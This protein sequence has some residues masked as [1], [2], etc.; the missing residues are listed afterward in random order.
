MQLRSHIF[1]EKF[2]DPIR[3][4]TSF[5]VSLFFVM[6][7]V[8]AFEI[9]AIFNDHQIDISKLSFSLNGI[10][11]DL[12]FTLFLGGIFYPFFWMAFLVLKPISEFFSRSILILI[13]FAYLAIDKYY[14]ESLTPLAADFWGYSYEDLATTIQTSADI[15]LLDVL[16]FLFFPILALFIYNRLIKIYIIHPIYPILIVTITV[17]AF[18]FPN[19]IL[20]DIS[21]FDSEADYYLTQN[22]ADF[23]IDKSIT[24]FQEKEALTENVQPTFDQNPYP[25][26]QTF[27]EKDQLSQYINLGPMPPNF[28]FILVESLGRS[29][30]G[31][32]AVH[33]G[34]TPYL[35]S[36]S[37]SSL[38]WENCLAPTGRTFGILPNMFGSLPFGTIG[39]NAL[40]KD[41]PQH[42]TL[43]S[44]A[45]KLNYK[46]HYF[47]GGN[48]DFDNQSGFLKMQDVD[49]ILGENQFPS[50]Y[51]KMP[52]NSGGFSW[53]YADKDVFDL[54]QKTVEAAKKS[55]RIDV[56]M[57]L[58]N[59][60]PFKVPDPTYHQ[61][62]ETRL[63]QL[64]NTDK[65]TFTQYQNIFECLLYTDD[66]IRELIDRYRKRPD[67]KNTIFIITGDHRMIPIEH[68]NAIDRFH[69]PL[70][71]WSPMLKETRSMQAL[72]SQSQVAPT[73]LSLLKNKYKLDVPEKTAFI[74]TGLSFEKAFTTKLTQPIMK[75]KGD[76]NLIVHENYFLDNGLLYKI[77]PQL[78]L[79]KTGFR[80][81]QNELQEQLDNFKEINNY[82]TLNN[83]LYKFDPDAKKLE[84]E[85]AFSND[86]LSTLKR[87]NA[88]SISSDSLLSLAQSLFRADNYTD[89]KTVLQFTLNQSPTYADVRIFLGRIHYWEDDNDL[90]EKEFNLAL[91][92]SPQYDE[93]YRALTNFL[94]KTQ[95]YQRLNSLCDSAIEFNST[96]A[97]YLYFK[98]LAFSKLNPKEE[99][100]ILIDS[101]LQLNTNNIDLQELK[102]T[103]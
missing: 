69:V 71:I 64:P 8:R 27:Q 63:S 28:V 17:A 7:F 44:E 13:T 40:D 91:Q 3:L 31:P 5:L 96:D 19:Y 14:L 35:D 32:N 55:P 60:E 72:V 11:N 74:N 2:L 1:Q 86:Q 57:T 30:T 51:S 42:I 76:L 41:M 48:V 25:L 101:L 58:V 92:N 43:L 26:L 100:I 24:Y 34:F 33:G 68:R 78:E 70:M 82:V 23:F 80:I 22:K 6:V 54:A 87:L 65:A 36:L 15:S 49:Y 103:L 59:H 16:A 73:F 97:E 9:F 20:K 52:A 79:D 98:G 21:D 39:F 12:V 94:A 50:N 10:L 45:K 81:K 29:F 46:T 75:N 66:A 102:D 47:Y 67:F 56:Y 84:D 99:S 93:A 61:K 83:R 85:F 89:A 62:F 18:L 53:G 90:A 95:K 37:T 38:Y 4:Y 77:L 88:D